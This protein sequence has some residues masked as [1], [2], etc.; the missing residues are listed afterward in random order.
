MIPCETSG[1]R[2]LY[3]HGFRF[4]FTPLAGV[5]FAFPSR[6]WSTIGRQLV[7]SLGGWSPHLQTGF[8]VSRPTHAHQSLAFTYG[9]FT[10]CA[11][12]FQYVRLAQ[13]QLLGSFP[14]ARR[15][16]GNLF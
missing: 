13:L 1:S 7:F 5:L 3:A 10:L 9:G 11:R 4:S 12:T 2:C 8:L 16:L 15:Y 6:Y 14:F